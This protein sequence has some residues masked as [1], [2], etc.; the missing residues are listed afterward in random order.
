[1]TVAAWKKK[2]PKEHCNLSDAVLHNER[3]ILE[4]APARPVDECIIIK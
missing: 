3:S 2:S 1:M 4:P